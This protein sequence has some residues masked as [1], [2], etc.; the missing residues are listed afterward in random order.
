MSDDK[1][2]PFPTLLQTELNNKKG[3]Y[4]NVEIDPLFYLFQFCPI[5]LLHHAGDFVSK[6]IF[7]FLKAFALLKTDHF[8]D[9]VSY[10]HLDVYKRQF[11]R[12]RS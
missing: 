1:L 2:H 4:P 11:P 10:T 5:A 7:T 3:I 8:L 9:P 12:I 6:I